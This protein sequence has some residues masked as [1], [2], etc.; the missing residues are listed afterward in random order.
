VTSSQQQS[1]S[2][3]AGFLTAIGLLVSLGVI[4]RLGEWLIEQ[5]Q[6]EATVNWIT[7]PILSVF[8]L[9]T[10]V[11]LLLILWATVYMAAFGPRVSRR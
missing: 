2:F 5:P 4:A 3:A 10:L 7:T 1:G 11:I 9:V 6:P 8:D